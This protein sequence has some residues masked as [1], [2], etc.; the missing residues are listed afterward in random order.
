MTAR[1]HHGTAHAVHR[2]G[3]FGH[4]AFPANRFTCHN[5]PFVALSHVTVYN[6]DLEDDIQDETGTPFKEFL[7]EVLNRPKFNESGNIGQRLLTCQNHLTDLGFYNTS[8]SQI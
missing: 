4:F 3:L 7:V 1:C 2:N 8:I 5:E 6:R